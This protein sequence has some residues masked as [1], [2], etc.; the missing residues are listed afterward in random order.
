MLL[1]FSPRPMRRIAIA[2]ECQQVVTEARG[3]LGLTP[4]ALDKRARLGSPTVA[5]VESG[6]TQSTV[7]AP[8][9]RLRK[10]LQH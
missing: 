9:T 6:R 1:P 8:L 7:L 4:R 5:D 10:V 2:G 3:R